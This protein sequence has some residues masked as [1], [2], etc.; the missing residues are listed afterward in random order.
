MKEIIIF[1]VISF[2]GILF[3]SFAGFGS[4]LFAI[5]LLTIFFTPQKAVPTF[6]L[7]SLSMNI[8]LVL[9]ARK[10]IEW[11]RISKLLMGGLIGIPIGAYFLAHF[12]PAVIR[13][14]ISSVT[15]IFAILFLMKINIPL[16]EDTPT[17]ITTGFLSGIIGGSIGES[18]PPVVIFGLARKW[19]KNVFRTTLLTYF[20]FLSIT[21]NISYFLLGLIG[22]ENLKFFLFAVLPG[23][24][25]C[26]LGIKIKN[27]V[28]EELFRKVVLYIILAVAIIGLLKVFVPG[29]KH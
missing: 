11:K 17:Q 9:E 12:S 15:F 8:F 20:L 14:I 19:E 16:R 24:V 7:L 6:S 13:I 21:S 1:T 2:L 25:A 26:S 27:S 10:H 23:F 28:S 5:P 29:L 18:G 22:K 4:A 3:P